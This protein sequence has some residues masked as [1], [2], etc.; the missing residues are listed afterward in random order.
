MLL[1]ETSCDSNNLGFRPAFIE[2]G[3]DECEM[4][5]SVCVCET[6]QLLGCE[7]GLVVEESADATLVG[8]P[9]Q[10]IHQFGCVL[11]LDRTQQSWSAIAQCDDS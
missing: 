10:T 6:L 9:L 8:D 11:G 1:A 7:A 2:N 5:L 3:H 4:V